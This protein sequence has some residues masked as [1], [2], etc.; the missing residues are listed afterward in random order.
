MISSRD[1]CGGPVAGPR[2]GLEA[3]ISYTENR[4]TYCARCNA[5]RWHQVDMR[6]DHDYRSGST[7]WVPTL[8]TCRV[9]RHVTDSDDKCHHSPACVV[10]PATKG[11]NTTQETRDEIKRQSR[12]ALNGRLR[13]AIPALLVLVP[14]A[15]CMCVVVVKIFRGE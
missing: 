3:A 11:A 9:C 10:D 14:F 5:D 4:I 2:S 15:I 6:E 8:R 7:N 13:W 1:S 12:Q